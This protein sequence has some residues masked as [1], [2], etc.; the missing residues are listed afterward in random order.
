MAAS[1]VWYKDG[2]AEEAK[3]VTRDLQA[4]EPIEALIERMPADVQ[5]KT[6]PSTANA[7]TAHDSP[8]AATG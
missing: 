2:Y 1:K 7:K 5:M 4:A 3:Q 8:A 6:A